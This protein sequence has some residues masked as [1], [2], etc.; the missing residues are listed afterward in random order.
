MFDHGLGGWE[1]LIL[2]VVLVVVLGYKR[3]PEAARSLGRSMRILKAE[4]KGLHDDDDRR[5]AVR[6]DELGQEAPS[7]ARLPVAPPI[8]TQRPVPPAPTGVVP[9]V[10]APPPGR[11]AESPV[12][13]VDSERH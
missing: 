13:S 10:G 9:P 1:L 6:R 5:D 2:L 4:T 12:G 3:L 7:A 11:P 8:D